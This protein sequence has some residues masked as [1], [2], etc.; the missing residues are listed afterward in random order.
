MFNSTVLE[1]AVGLVFCY[2][3]V[4]LTV[5]SI[6]EA[7]ASALNLRASTLLDGIKALLNDPKF[8]GIARDLYNHASVNPR[9]NGQ[10][11]SESDLSNKP[12]YIPSKHFALALIDILQKGPAAAAQL[13]QTIAAIQDPQIRQ[14]LQGMYARAA[15]NMEKFQDEVA[16]WFDN[17]MERVSGQYKRRSQLMCLVI[18]FVIAGLFNI[19]SFHL[20]RSL[21]EHPGL[22]VAIAGPTSLDANEAFKGLQ[23]LPIGWQTFPPELGSRWEYFALFGGWLVTASTALFG[24]PFWFDLLQNITQLRGT[25]SKPRSMTAQ[26]PGGK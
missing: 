20:F 25:G 16:A 17:G 3:A 18:A 11:Q 21:W 1:V 5:S 8:E 9:D 12:S 2:C 6:N 22:A 24:A 23:L 15:G 19:D 4:S 10:A 7:I 26:K 14:L 13:D